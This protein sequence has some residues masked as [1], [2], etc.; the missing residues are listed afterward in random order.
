MGK[1]R[2]EEQIAEEIERMRQ[3]ISKHEGKAFSPFRSLDTVT[4]N[5]VCCLVFGHGFSYDDPRLLRILTF[6]EQIFQDSSF[7]GLAN[8]VPWLSYLPFSGFQKIKRLS[9]SNHLFYKEMMAIARQNHTPG[10]PR[11][12]I[13]MYL[14]NQEKIQ[15]EQA[16]IAEW[17]DDVDLESCISDLFGAGTETSSTTLK[18]GLL[19]MI[20]QPDI[21]DKVQAELDAEVGR[22]RTPSLKDRPRLPYTEA[23]LLE[24]QRIGSITPLGVPRAASR[25][26]KINGYDVPQGTM[27]MPN[28]WAVHHDVKIWD[29]PEL[30]KPERFLNSDGSVNRR[31]EL[32]P[33]SIGKPCPI[34]HFDWRSALVFLLC[35]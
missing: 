1:F 15:R 18:W 6:L 28:L 7:T 21:Q 3:S 9:T 11:T 19:Y 24:M 32:I 13:D 26:A 17:F 10:E 16:D 35:E 14:D 31:E 29:D 22:N 34:M 20:L 8:F 23:T 33:F 2:L 12:F 4:C 27:V 25:D 30:F 5:V